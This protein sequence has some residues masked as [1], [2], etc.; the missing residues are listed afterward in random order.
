MWPA[1]NKVP[2][3]HLV[4]QVAREIRL[5]A[6]L[7]HR[8]ILPLYAAF[9]DTEGINLVMASSNKDPASLCMHPAFYA[10]ISPFSH[11]LCQA[12][13]AGG[14]LYSVLG[15]SGGYL[16]E[17]RVA[18]H[19]MPALLSATAQMHAQVI[20]P[21]TMWVTYPVFLDAMEHTSHNFFW[22]I[23]TTG[24]LGSDVASFV[25]TCRT[26][27]TA[28][29]SQRT[30]CSWKTG[31]CAWLTWAWRWT[32]PSTSQSHAWAHWT[33]CHQRWQF[34]TCSFMAATVSTPSCS[35]AVVL[36]PPCSSR[37]LWSAACPLTGTLWVSEQMAE[38]CLEYQPQGD[39][40]KAACYGL[41][42]DVWATGVLAYELLVG[43][44]PFE[45]DTKEE[46][47][48]KIMRGEVW[49]PRHISAGA[50][51]F[52]QQVGATA[53]SGSCLSPA[54]GCSTCVCTVCRRYKSAQGTGRALRSN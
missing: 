33:T 27:C 45:A 39:P 32:W 9:E 21:H 52:I 18:T 22:Y 1:P 30:S 12:F 14:S 5:H 29:S 31:M 41:P 15:Q 4:S 20:H 43:G 37:I 53:C 26:Y 40:R 23:C 54:I 3:T 50:Q 24:S 51:H 10:M 47:Y 19:I 35:P 25:A 13:A 8:N 16:P 7:Q 42:A 36:L 34:C 49:L 17:E 46:T 2:H 28:T 6:R 38:V 11:V 44:S 48:E